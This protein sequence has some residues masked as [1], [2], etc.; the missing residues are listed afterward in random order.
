[1]SISGSMLVAGGALGAY[2]DALAVTGDNIAN[3]NTVGFKASR[4]TFADL[5]PD[6]DGSIETGNGV[7]LADFTKPFQQGALETTPNVT[8]L[9]ISGNGFF[10]V[11]DPATNTLFYTRAGQFHL[12]AAGRLVNEADLALQGSA[13]DIS[14]GASLSAPAQATTSAAIELNLDAG[15]ITPATPFPGSADASSEA[16]M[17]ASNFSSVVT[18][19]DGLGA[20]HDLTFLYRR[21]APDTW[22]YRVV[23]PRKELDAGAPNSAELRQVSAPGTLVFDGSGQF[24]AAASTLTDISGLNWVNG[25]SQTLGAANL[26]FAGS[27]QFGQPSFVFSAVQNGFGAGSFTGMT[28]DEQGVL[29]GHF[30][31]GAT[32]ALGGIVLATFANLDDLDP[33][34]A[35]LFLPSVESGAAQTG[36]PDQNGFGQIASGTLELSTVDLAQQFIALINSQ[37]AFQVNSR[38]VTTADQMYALAAQLKPL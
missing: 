10:V 26:S 38:V 25:V 24:D 16:W 13:G 35:T 32:Q 28:I 9:A 8:D 12:D 1:M 33:Q 2:G 30:S 7:R 17:A 19:Y 21:T 34:G 29:T 5:L 36:V 20:G 31:N 4:F 27:V 11:R 15:A 6:S 3:F 23:A 14:I 37:R 18:V 22:E